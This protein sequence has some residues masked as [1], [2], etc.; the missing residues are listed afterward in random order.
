MVGRE[1]KGSRTGGTEPREVR[2]LTQAQLAQR[3]GV[4]QRTLEGWRYRGKGPAFLRLEGGR[5][6]YRVIDVE[7]FELECLQTAARAGDP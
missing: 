6:A 2:H 1:A 5:I 4:S 7:R 3:L